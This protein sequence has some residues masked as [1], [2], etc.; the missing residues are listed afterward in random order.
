[1]ITNHSPF[2]ALKLFA[3]YWRTVAVTIV[4]DLQRRPQI[5][6]QI[7]DLLAK[8]VS[9]ILTIT[10]VHTVPFLVLRKQTNLLQRIADIQ[11]LSIMTLCREPTNMAAIL[12]NIL[13]QDSADVENLVISLLN[14]VSQEFSNV[15]CAEL[16]KSEPQATATELLKIAGD[17][18][19]A[20]QAEAVTY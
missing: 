12:A 13:L 4:Q 17:N 10:Q 19:E 15:D 2:T 8:P 1:M 7:A 20:R 6:Q 18:D 9:E 5:I 11:R 16:L 14:S 3:P